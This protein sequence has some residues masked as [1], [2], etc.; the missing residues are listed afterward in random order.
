MEKVWL[1]SYQSGVPAEIN[2]DTYNSINDIFNESCQKYAHNTAYVNLGS[3]LS[4]QQLQE[5]VKSFA[6]FLQSE[7]KL[8]KGDRLALMMPNL[9]QYPIAMFGALQA[10]LIVVNVNPLYTAREL[11]HQL[12]DS[13]AKAI[14]VLANVAHTLQAVLKSCPIKHIIVTEIGDCFPF[15]KSLLVNWI[16]KYL[17]KMI[18]AWDIPGHIKFKQVLSIGKNRNFSAVKVELQDIAYL[19]YTGG[20]TGTVKGAMLS[21]RNMVANLEQ[22][23]AWLK[24][25]LK[26]DYEIIITAIP[27]YHI[28]SL[29]ANCLTFMKIGAKNILITNP[30]DLPNFIKEM[31]KYPFT[32]ITGVN[33]LFNA[34]LNHEKFAKLDFFSLRITLGGGM[35]VQRAVANRWKQITKTTLVEAYG[36]TETSPAACINPLDLKEYNGSVGLPVSSTDISI[37]DENGKECGFNQSGELWIKGPQ[38]MLGYWNNEKETK[39]T[40]IDG[41]VRTG[42]IATVDEAGFVRIVDRKK[43]MILI[44][45]FNVYPNEIEA[46]VAMMPAVKEVA[47]IGKKTESG[48]EMVKAFIVAKDP[49]LTVEQVKEFCRTQLT[50]YKIPKEI[51][52][53]ND[54]PKTN[55]GKILRRALRE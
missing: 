45:G 40:L 47:V 17:K 44:S 7:L 3:S 36:L 52:F 5:K 54:L 14:V 21:H 11:E 23:F 55:V 12:K 19:Q 33:T 51:E 4:Y 15:P 39:E 43:D 31:S 20:T 24:P 16:V 38:V 25:S 32:V 10:G 50:S 18:P 27:L 49:S 1:T 29:T 30:R 6:S 53:R 34:L 28:F 37:R 8:V 35:S 48:D 9:L 42:D 26:G 46:V 22:A 41:W 13:G 2:P